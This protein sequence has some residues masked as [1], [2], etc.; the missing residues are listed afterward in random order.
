MSTF[1]H[2]FKKFIFK[3]NVITRCWLVTGAKWENFDANPHT[4]LCRKEKHVW[5]SQDEVG[6]QLVSGGNSVANV[7]PQPSE[8]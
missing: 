2:F 4:D 8:S 3:S 7:V 1:G 6:L 5:V